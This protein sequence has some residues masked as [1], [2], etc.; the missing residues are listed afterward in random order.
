MPLAITLTASSSFRDLFPAER[1]AQLTAEAERLHQRT[2][3]I[4]TDNIRCRWQDD[5]NTGECRFDCFDPVID[6]SPVCGDVARDP[7]LLDS[8][9]V[10]Y[11]EPACLFKNKLIFKAPG[12]LR[13][14]AGPL[15]GAR[16][17]VDV[18]SMMNHD[19]HTRRDIPQV[20][21]IAERSRPRSLGGVLSRAAR[22]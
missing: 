20:P 1:I 16:K 12:T 5:V 10:L 17:D 6:L 13:V 9:A 14:A 4:D 2:D 7:Q 22:H 19:G 18:L 15:R 3:L 8:L 11:G 21:R